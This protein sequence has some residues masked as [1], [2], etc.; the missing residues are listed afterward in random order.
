MINQMSTDA[1]AEDVMVSPTSFAQ[2][3]LWF[4][5]Q[6]EPGSSVYNISTGF[7]VTGPL[8]VAALEQSL[9][10][11]IR[12]H[13]AL[14]TTFSTRE[15][16]PLQVIAAALKLDMPMID[17]SS[18]A[19]P[20]REA[21]MQRYVGE[22][23]RRP[24]D[25]NRGPLLR[26]TVLRLEGEEHV[27]LL[28]FHHIVSDGWSMGIFLRELTALYGAFCMGGR[29]PLPEL[30]IQYA[31]FAAWQRQWLQGEVLERQLSY[32]RKQLEG[33]STLEFPTDCP[34]PKVQTFR[35]ARESV[36]LSQSLSEALR[37]LGRQAGATLF[38]TLV[39]ALTV[40]LRRY[41]GQGD[42]VVGTPVAGR[43]RTE[44]E[45]LIGFFVNT[46][47]LRTDLSG[48][49]TFREFLGRVRGMALD[50]YAHQDLP[51]E[52]LVEELQ[53][54]RDLSRTPLFQVFLNMD[55]PEARELSLYGLT[56]ERLMLFEPESPFDFTLYVKEKKQEIQFELVYNADLFRQDRMIWMLGQFQTL[57]AAIAANPNQPLSTLR[58][59][60][61]A[62]RHRLSQRSNVVCP[63][64]PFIEFRKEDI[65]QSI[66]GRFEQQVKQFPDHIAVRTRHH[67]WTY[68][69]LNQTANQIARRIL[70]LCDRGDERIALLLDH[71]AAMIAG[72]FGVL[73]AGKSYVPLDAAHPKARLSYILEDS[74]AGA[75]LTN[76]GN[77]AFAKTLSNGTVELIDMDEI[78]AGTPTS[79]PNL[80]IS[81]E[82][83]AYIL[84]TSGSTGQPKGVM[85]NH[86]NVLHHIRNYTNR[87]HLNASDRLTLISSYSFDAAV[88]DI[89]GA[90]LNGASLY[91]MNIKDETP[92]ALSGWI[93]EEEITIYHSTPTVYRYLVGTP[94]GKK[95]LSTTRFVVLGGEEVQKKDTDLFKQNFPPQSIF[96]NGL[97]PTESTVTLQYFIDHKTEIPG[98]RVPVGYP[99]E[100][101]EVL[102]LDEAGRQAELYGEIGI[103]GA[104]VALGYWRKP[105]MTEAAFLPDPEGGARRIYRTG[106]MGRLLPDGS[107][108]FV[109]RKDGQVKIRGH[110]VEPGEIESALREHP[111]V[112]ESVVI[113][114]ED[115]PGDPSAPLPS[116][117]S[118][119]VEDRAGKRLVAYIV[120]SRRLG[121]SV[122]ELREFLKERLP[123]YMIPSAFM[124]LETLPLTPNG[125]VDRKAL[126]VP[127][128][129]GPDLEKSFVAPRSPIEKL[130]ARIWA[131]VLGLERVG[132]HDNFFELG[133]HSLKATQVMSR[134]RDAFLVEMPLRT[135]FEAPTVADLAVAIVRSQTKR[136]GR[137][138]LTEV[139]TELEQLSEDEVQTALLQKAS[140]VDET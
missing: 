34:R 12:R 25:L 54:E 109:G 57:L 140:S 137:Q 69:E 119:R 76:T 63:A 124:M 60:T 101:T 36:V 8:N 31:N 2:Q 52:K 10:E 106:D 89:F 70:R 3:R 86:C 40:L 46:L 47:V 7:R 126:P 20:E 99:V 11:I 18:V 49:P 44:I 50:A 39:A 95:D 122:G 5:D 74:Q 28:T 15:G 114:R 72:I 80:P 134:L 55:G 131:E 42:I 121:P 113:A 35:G 94:T 139:L 65:E 110:R 62:E 51:F 128:Q 6:L 56:V 116:G 98:N 112:R 37:R 107:I 91:P 26:M 125:K 59:L 64:N 82:T 32:W 75:I 85:Q 13:E 88:M 41:T 135:V 133:G 45:D 24:F 33:V 71:N 48:D 67:Q 104:H 103:R 19:A 130:L 100:D 61:G 127:D 129:A 92:S 81:P 115:A 111:R 66:P 90:L 118:L 87:L 78:V 4:F 120:P 23:A 9:N 93:A 84:Y 97:G 16:Q 73:K 96:V 27:L 68:S 1:L 21:Q 136:V 14:R 132:I 108:A 123:D 117:L 105:E 58:L 29:S 138:T 30:P 102:L 43:N 79:N 53:P 38:M 22:E 77:L 83:L 17:L